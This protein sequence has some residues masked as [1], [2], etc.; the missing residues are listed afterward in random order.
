MKAQLKSLLFWGVIV[1]INLAVVVG[2]AYYFSSRY[3]VVIYQRYT[4][5][6]MRDL[7]SASLVRDPAAAKGTRQ[8]LPP[9]SI[10]FTAA[11]PYCGFKTQPNVAG[12]G[13][14]MSV[15]TNALGHRSPELGPKQPG[16][17]RVAMVGG[18]VALQ[19]SKNEAAIVARLTELLAAKGYR[20]EYVNAGVIA[21][22]S[23]QE[24]NILLNDLVDLKPDLVISFDGI[25]DINTP[26]YVNGRIGWPPIRWDPPYDINKNTGKGSEQ[27]AK[28]YYPFIVPR[29]HNT[30]R[31]Q[32]DAALRNYF[33]SIDK[34]A[35]ICKAYD[36][37]YLAV[38]QPI[39]NFR[40]G[41]CEDRADGPLDHKQLFYCQSLKQFADWQADKHQGAVYLSLIDVL[42]ADK[43]LY[44]DDCH[45][46]DQGNTLTARALLAAIEAEPSL[47][48]I[49][50]R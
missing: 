48:R 43:N 11:H 2:A 19:G 17:L 35:R 26:M 27:Q 13:A 41:D 18:S 25:N 40:P 37:A 32:V 29:L 33:N 50:A 31:S 49:L 14:A 39:R 8:D 30:S 21:A 5:Q 6:F 15:E 22:V 46:V 7:A 16:V 4:S 23:N 36:I 34:M 12:L 42:H 1:G 24:V 47:S 3:R 28:S 38:F 10:D 20:A 9:Q 45:F 44:I